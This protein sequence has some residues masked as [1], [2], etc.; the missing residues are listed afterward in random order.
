MQ[1][2]KPLL[3]LEIIFNK[4]EEYFVRKTTQFYVK[5]VNKDKRYIL[6]FFWRINLILKFDCFYRNQIRLAQLGKSF[7]AITQNTLLIT[8]TP[9][10]VFLIKLH[11]TGRGGGAV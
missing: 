8:P 11:M 3:I 2:A 7:G 6:M 10:T 1:R 9:H 5:M 4:I